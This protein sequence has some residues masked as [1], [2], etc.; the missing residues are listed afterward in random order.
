MTGLILNEREIVIPGD[1]IAS[2]MDYLPGNGAFREEED[3]YSLQLGLVSLNGRFVK[4]I[5]LTGK[6]FPKEGDIVIGRV[7]DVGFGMWMIDIG[8]AYS[9]ILNMRET[10]EFIDKGADLSHYYDFND[11]I[12]AEVTKV[13]RYKDV[14]LTMKGQGLRKINGGK[15][16]DITPSKVPRVIGKQGS[17][18]NMIKEGTGCNIVVG[19]NGKVWIKGDKVEDEVKATEV[20]LK[21]EHESHTQGLTD[22]IKKMLEGN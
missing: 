9:A 11:V 21:I 17:M 19:Q 4:V 12:I 2:G 18:I 20:I 7:S 13:V 5:P 8:C 6:Y 1:K 22:T 15:I 14:S 3:I 10:P 16:I